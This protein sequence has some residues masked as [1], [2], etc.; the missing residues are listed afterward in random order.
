MDD[1]DEGLGADQR[2]PGLGRTHRQLH[3][4]D[5]TGSALAPARGLGQ[6]IDRIRPGRHQLQLASFRT[7]GILLVHDVAADGTA[8][9]VVLAALAFP[10]NNAEDRFRVIAAEVIQFADERL[11]PGQRDDLVDAV[12]PG[13]QQTVE[14]VAHHRVVAFHRRADVAVLPV[15]A[16]LDVVQR[17]NGA[18]DLFQM[19]DLRAPG[20]I[21]PVLFQQRRQVV[22]GVIDQVRQLFPELFHLFQ[23]LGQ[24]LLVLG[25][26]ETGDP[27]HGQGE[28]FFH[29]LVGHVTPQ[30]IPEGGDPLVDFG[31]SQLMGL[32]LF[33][34][35]V[36]PVFKEYLGQRLGVEELVLPLQ[37][38]FQLPFQVVEQFF[39][40]PL[41][42]LGHA[43]DAGPA[44]PDHGQIHR[45][46]FGA[47]G[48]H[49]QRLPGLFQ[50]VAPGGD[51]FDF[52][53]GAG[54]IPDAGNLDLVL[55]G[56]F[57]DG[58]DEAFG[59]AHR[60][61]L[62][63][64]QLPV[65]FIQLDL[66]PQDDPAV[67]VGVFRNIHQ[68]PLTEVRIDGEGLMPEFADLGLEQFAE[69]VRQDRGRHAHGDAVAAQHEKTRDLHRKHH[70]LL[71]PAVVGVHELRQVVVEKDLPSQLGKAALD[72]P[73]SRRGTARDGVPV[74][75][76]L[77]D[78]V[79][80]VGQHHQRVA[81]GGVPVGVIVHHVADDVGRLVGP[82]VVDLLERPEDAALDR[83]QAVVHVGDRPVL[84]DIRGVVQ[85]IPVHHGPQIG[86]IAPLIDGFF[87]FAGFRLGDL[88]VFFGFVT[89]IC[90]PSDWS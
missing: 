83:L 72:V 53:L 12:L 5:L 41:D 69:V 4:V 71:A 11:V 15:P 62:A 32:C 73:R 52:R 3:E 14:L 13:A 44:F 65:F 26:V 30:L 58:A 89:H 20:E 50:I 67:A 75:P 81:D 10:I 51:D 63:D 66:G 54:I 84:D 2:S 21:R 22:D 59:G 31:Q 82:A 38:Q 88:R 49:V 25:D 37:R 9:A 1:L 45:Y 19:F 47:V 23:D 56:G 18:V 74:V 28:K 61:D 64:H 86:V 76:L 17:G 78:V 48:V 57:F 6:Q 60:R 85:K 90:S 80:L 7:E 79:F 70:G 39:R 24:F 77:D 40:V 87:A 34:P 43:H 33:D 36:D 8:L 27:P 42:D 29:I 55:F 68:A 46:R 35:L 16:D